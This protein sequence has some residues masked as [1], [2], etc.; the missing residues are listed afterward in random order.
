MTTPVQ[1]QTGVYFARGLC[2]TVGSAVGSAT[3]INV[4]ATVTDVPLTSRE[5]ATAAVAGTFCLAKDAAGA[6]WSIQVSSTTDAGIQACKS[7][8]TFSSAAGC[9]TAITNTAPSITSNG[10]GAAAA[11]NVAEN[12]TGVTTVTATDPET[13]TVTFSITGGADQGKFSI[14]SGGALT[15]NTAPDFETPTDTEPNNSYIVTITATDNGA[16]NL[17]DTQ[18]ITVTVTDA[19]AAQTISFTNPGAQT[20]VSGGTVPLTATGGGSGNAVIL[21]ST[22]TGVCTVTGSTVTMVSA[23]TCSI[24]ADQDRRQ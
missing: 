3:T 4:P 24:T 18:T 13:D 10:G 8:D 21:A 1:A 5:T 11:I 19:E 6:Y 20:F 9:T 7:T 17:T 2:Q 23:G 12:Q 15:F 14:T 22:T 16:G